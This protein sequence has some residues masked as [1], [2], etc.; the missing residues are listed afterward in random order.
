MKNI[1]YFKHLYALG[2]TEQFLYEIAKAYMDYDITILY[3][4]ADKN[5]I[6]RISKYVRCIKRE[7]GKKY[8]CDRAFFNFNIDCIDDIIST[9][10][11][12]GF[13]SHA[14]FVEL[15]Y[16]PPIEHP[17]LNHF[18]GVSLFAC[19]RLEEYARM[20]GM[21]IKAELIYNPLTLEPQK[22]IL[23]LVCASRLV[24]P[25]KGGNRVR[26]FIDACDYYCKLHNEH[27]FM[28]I[29]A[30]G[31]E[32]NSQ[33]VKVMSP[34]LDVR[35]Y[36][37]NADVLVQLSN[38]METYGYSINEALGYHKRVV[39][40]KLSVLK[41]LPIPDGATLQCD[42]DMSNVDSIVAEMFENANTTFE[43]TPPYSRW[44]EVLKP[45]KSKYLEEIKN[46]VRVKC[47]VDFKDSEINGYRETG[48]EFFV[49]K[50]RAIELTDTSKPG[51]ALVTILKT[52]EADKEKKVV[53][54]TTHKKKN[55]DK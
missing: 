45:G 10:N 38:D 28:L 23:K 25:V 48:E 4:S 7:K 55:A 43:Y 29:F 20:L 2:G 53:N 6:N 39:C 36:I 54:K 40:T 17:K 1:Y 44:G 21:N 51:G 41:E 35:Q 14:N 19:D 13:V 18:F 16:K 37:A 22:K 42:F 11:F 31:F 26:T 52:E 30:D 50:E 15:G 46:M 34:T 3:D 47:I 49:T 9:E 5:Q 27:Y 8:E 12:Y 24:D 32:C 33:N